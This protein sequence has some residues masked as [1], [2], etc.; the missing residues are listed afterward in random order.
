MTRPLTFAS[1][2]VI[3]QLTGQAMYVKRNIE[4]RARVATVAVEKQ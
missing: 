2:D 3:E 1:V 4:T